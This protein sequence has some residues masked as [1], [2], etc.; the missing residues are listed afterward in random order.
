M[1]IYTKAKSFDDQLKA[2]LHA[3]TGDEGFAHD[4]QAAETTDDDRNVV[5][6][7]AP[8]GL[9]DERLTTLMSPY[10]CGLTR[11]RPAVQQA[12][13]FEALLATVEDLRAQQ[14]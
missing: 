1:Q 5:R 4:A 9:S 7:A 8:T 3:L 2:T 12:C 14:V 13:C 6:I 11:R 10:P